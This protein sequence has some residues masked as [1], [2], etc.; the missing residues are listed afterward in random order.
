MRKR[1]LCLVGLVFTV[2]L[3]TYACT[4]KKSEPV[5]AENDTEIVADDVSENAVTVTLFYAN[6][7]L[8]DFISEEVT[9]SKLSPEEIVDVM[10]SHN[11][12]STDTRVLD[13]QVVEGDQTTLRLNLNKQFK[14][15]IKLMSEEGEYYIIGSITDSF[16]SAYDADCILILVDGETLSTKYHDYT[17]TLS[18][19]TKE[20]IDDNKSEEPELL[21]EEISPDHYEISDQHEQT[22]IIDVHFPQISGL[23]DKEKESTINTYLLQVAMG[24]EADCLLSYELNYEVKCQEGDFLAIAYYGYLYYDGA[25]YPSNYAISFNFNLYDGTCIRLKEIADLSEVS[26]KIKDGKFEIVNSEITV[27]DVLQYLTENNINLEEILN[28]FDIDAATGSYN[29]EGYS[30]QTNEGLFLLL[31]VNNALGD[32]AE[33]KLTE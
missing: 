13:F 21:E 10:A 17:E 22:D 32:F 25:A 3:T 1:L 29:A 26:Q 18:F 20:E 14:E 6:A 30:Y 9:L 2:I 5:M 8:T 15:Y 7:M 27:E 4:S 16:L 11:I 12:V 19:F 28:Q 23:S 31:K 24:Y 33:I